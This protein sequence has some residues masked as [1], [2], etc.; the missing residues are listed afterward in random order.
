VG[1]PSGVDVGGLILKGRIDRIDHSPAGDVFIID[2]KS[3]SVVSNNKIGTEEAL[4]LPL[5]MLALGVERPE[6]E[7]LG[8]AYL[9]PKERKRSGVVAAGSEDILGAAA[10]ACAVVCEEDFQDLLDRSLELAKK[11]AQGMQSGEIAPLPGRKCP[12]WCGLAPVCRA[13]KGSG[14][15]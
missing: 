10:G 1:G 4:Q 14:R 8:G 2:Y 15:W 3:G 12:T 13:R 5:Y 7:V 9:T 6:S 11:A